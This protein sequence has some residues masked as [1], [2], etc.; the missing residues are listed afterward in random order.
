[1]VGE[2]REEKRK[3]NL[4]VFSTNRENVRYA[5]QIIFDF[6]HGLN[7]HARHKNIYVGHFLSSVSSLRITSA[8]PSGMPSLSAS[9]CAVTSAFC[10]KM[11]SRV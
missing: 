3:R 8:S 11:L 7:R 9:S 10:G 5:R 2:K 6:S 4:S 1:M